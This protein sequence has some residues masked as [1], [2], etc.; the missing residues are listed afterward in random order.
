MRRTVIAIAAAAC[1]QSDLSLVRFD[2]ASG[3]LNKVYTSERK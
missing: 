2:G 3:I 1:R